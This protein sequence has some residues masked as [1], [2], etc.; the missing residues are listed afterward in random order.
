MKYVKRLYDAQLQERLKSAGAVLIRGVKACG[1]TETARQI[2]R[3]SIN[4]LL[5]TDARIAAFSLEQALNG[6]RPR[7]IDEWQE[8]PKIWDSAKVAIDNSSRKGLF[9]LTG[10]ATPKDDARIHSGVGRF[11][12]LEMYPMTWVEKGFAE[13]KNSLTRAITEGV[14]EFEEIDVSLAEIAEKI[15]LGGWPELLGS[16]H[17]EAMRFLQDYISLTCEADINRVGNNSRRRDPLKVRRLL[18]S[19]AR[20]ISTEASHTTLARDIAGD[21]SVDDET[22]AQYLDALSRLM[23]V[24]Y[25]PAFKP[26]ITSTYALR[27]TPVKH[28]VD[29]SLAAGALNLSVDKLVEDPLYLG[30]LFESCV[31]QNIRA[32][33]TNSGAVF[34]HYRN[35]IGKEVDLVIELPDGSWCAIEIKLGFGHVEEAAKNLLGFYES[36]DQSRTPKPSRLIVITGNGFA[37]KRDDGV[38]VI[39]FASFGKL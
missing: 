20:N 25:L 26:H 37:H 9:I 15:I 24:D 22:V 14:I 38:I 27:S 17:Q 18:E 8:F 7:L 23:I 39:P 36:I 29:A 21:Q 35:S 1:K 28:F 5:E 34:S 33:L 11:S 13:G 19:Y 31:V 3:S 10:S 6:E 32:T 30:L 4:L 2:A 12:V 16:T